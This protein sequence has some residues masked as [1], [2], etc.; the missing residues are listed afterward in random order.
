[1]NLRFPTAVLAICISS[2]LLTA[3]AAAPTVISK[4]SPSVIITLRARDVGI[5]DEILVNVGDQVSAGQTVAKLDDFRQLYALETLKR[6]LRNSSPLT[7]AEADL[8]EKSAALEEAQARHRRRQITD[9]ELARAAAQYEI[10]S[11]RLSLAKDAIEQTQA[12]R[13]LAEQA[14]NDRFVRS[15][16]AGRV[17]EVVKSLG[18]RAQPGDPIVLVGDFSKLTADQIFS[19][20]AAA[21]LIAGAMIPVRLVAGGPVIE[22]RIVSLTNAPKAANGEKLATLIFDNPEPSP[23]SDGNEF[24][25]PTEPSRPPGPASSVPSDSGRGNN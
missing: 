14:L 22:A 6:R 11:A 2:P 4:T 9:S 5:V 16:L 18:E 24:P 15:P 13:N 25:T 3:L 12:D 20:D 8:K 17:T 10:A 19:K 7:M 1:M 23:S 21:K